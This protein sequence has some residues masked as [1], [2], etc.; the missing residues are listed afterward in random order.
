MSKILTPISLWNNFNDK[1]E[2][3]P[4]TLGE[5]I[6][7][8]IKFEYLNFSGRDTG[9]GRV[10]VYGVLATKEINAPRECVL[11]LQDSAEEIDESLLEFFVN[12]GYNALCVDYAG[13]RDGLERYTQYPNN[14]AYANAVKSSRHKDYVDTTA[15]KTCWYE[16]VAVGIYA[17][18]F[19]KERFTTDNIGLVGIRDGGEI[20]WK[21]A[22]AAQFSCAVTISACGWGAYKGLAKFHGTEPD[23]DEERYR[24]IA[25]IDSQS[26]APYVRCPILILCTTNDK[27][28]DCDRAFDTF[29]RINPEFTRLSAITY[30]V[31]C[32]ACI[33]S[34]ST[35]DMLMFLDSNV[36]ERH[37]FMPRPVKVSVF[38]DEND[39][40]VARA[41][42]DSLGILEKCGVYYAENSYDYAT[43]D[44]VGAKLKDAVNAY[45]SD[46]YLNV[47]EKS[48]TIFVLCYAEYTNGF[49]VWSKL[50]VK[51]ISGS[52]RN[53]G[54]KSKIVYTNKF[55]KDCFS[56]VDCSDYAVGGMFL[57]DEDVLPTVLT[58][59]GLK[60]VYSKC[61]LL[62]YRI[63][64]LQYAPDKDSILKLDVCSE[65]DISLEVSLKNKD[66]GQI[67]SVKLYIL[68]GVWQCQTLR[69]KVFKNSNGISLTDFSSC[70][71]LAIVGSNKFAINNLIWL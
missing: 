50:A 66:D 62:T 11:I 45:E 18:K 63:K 55:G 65:E 14:I 26:Y 19:L 33:D 8:G 40:L 56:I 12:H 38:C 35:N 29:S 32:G 15:D 37:V 34:R 51:K 28:F 39:N 25:G 58:M 4:V 61:G 71:S 67:Y 16:W 53:G 69:T 52:F 54:A 1:L 68:G 5:R 21:L 47:Y 59:D 48:S 2:V 20:A 49:T 43:R 70:E 9:M 64:N 42:C 41:E 36:K 3:M 31:N 30:S 17:R 46:Y 6:D 7:E 27:R 10:T 23:F 22:Y 13:E 44:W 60:G 57:T 24:F